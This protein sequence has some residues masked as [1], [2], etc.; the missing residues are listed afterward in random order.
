[1]NESS[2]VRGI[3]SACEKLQENKTR[4]LLPQFPENH[5]IVRGMCFHA[6]SRC[7]RDK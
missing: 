4:V 3:L 6:I 5:K 7:N 2:C 1:M